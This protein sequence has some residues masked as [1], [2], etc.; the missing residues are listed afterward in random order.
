LSSLT[1][2]YLKIIVSH[3]IFFLTKEIKVVFCIQ[4]RCYRILTGGTMDASNRL[5]KQ[6]AERGGTSD[7][8]TINEV[9]YV[10]RAA[11]ELAG[12]N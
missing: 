8:E 9:D 12:A 3:V 6:H 11:P 1:L 4:Q 10:I 5:F 7:A 2:F